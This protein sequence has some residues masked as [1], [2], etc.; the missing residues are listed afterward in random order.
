MSLLDNTTSESTD[1]QAQTTAPS[2]PTL[3]EPR[4]NPQRPL[5]VEELSAAAAR[6]RAR[7]AREQEALLI[8]TQDPSRRKPEEIT[9]ILKPGLKKQHNIF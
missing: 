1:T 8:A 6:E 3:Q 9:L 7:I 2:Q 4:K 5:S